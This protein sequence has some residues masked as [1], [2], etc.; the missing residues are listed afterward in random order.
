L[1]I[2]W[3]IEIG[4]RRGQPGTKDNAIYSYAVSMA[5][6]TRSKPAPCNAAEG[7]EPAEIMSCAATRKSKTCRKNEETG[8]KQCKLASKLGEPQEP[9]K[10]K[11]S[12]VSAEKV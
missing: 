7:R 5:E 3:G 2:Y 10:K 8:R 11:M 1:I 4:V 9:K 6:E 12:S